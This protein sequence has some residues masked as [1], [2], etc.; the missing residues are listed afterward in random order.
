METGAQLMETVAQPDRANHATSMR[1]E[2]A[3]EASKPNATHPRQKAATPRSWLVASR[4]LAH[5]RTMPISIGSAESP[6]TAV[7]I[8]GAIGNFDEAIRSILMTRNPQYPRQLW[9]ETR[10]L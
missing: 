1:C 7:A 10:R 9:D 5:S 2:V 6:P 3:A 4:L 8:P